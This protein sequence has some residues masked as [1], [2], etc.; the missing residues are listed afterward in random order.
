[1]CKLVG[2]GRTKGR[3]RR[4]RGGGGERKEISVVT[5]ATKAVILDLQLHPQRVLFFLRI[6]DS[7]GH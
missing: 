6:P 1:M 2:G 3:R 4:K 7:P 5:S